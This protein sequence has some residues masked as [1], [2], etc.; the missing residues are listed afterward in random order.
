MSQV[1]IGDRMRARPER[2]GDEQRM[3]RHARDAGTSRV[4]AG[5]ASAEGERVGRADREGDQQAG[6][7]HHKVR[8]PRLPGLGEPQENMG[9]PPGRRDQPLSAASEAAP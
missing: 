6:Q 1:A 8:E 9:V 2:E 3:A 5:R 7:R 4:E